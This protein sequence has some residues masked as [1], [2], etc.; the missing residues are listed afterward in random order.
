VKSERLDGSDIVVSRVGLGC[1]NFGGRLDL[2]RTREV[3][4]AALDAGITFFDTADIYGN[5]GNSERFLGEL[6]QGRRDRVVL[7]TKFGHDMGDGFNGS[8]EYAGRA[9]RASLERLRMDHVDLFYYH[10]PDGVTPLAETLGAMQELV[11]EGLTRAIGCSNFSAEQLAEAEEIAGANGGSR[12]VAVQNE[13]S[14]L[15]RE[16]EDHVLPLAQRLGVGFVPYF[17]L[18]S[19]LLTGKYRRD[20]PRPKGTRLEGREIDDATFDRLDGLQTFA[21]ERGHSLLELAIAALASQ[22]G[23]AS[24]IAGATSAEQIRQNADAAGWELSA[25]DL[26]ELARI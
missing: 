11:R 8:G 2:E 23:V 19:G 14:L 16:A 24:V 26:A 15:E 4:D 21:R 5:R 25:D 10:R 22:P 1:N 18:A 17:P 7:A 20:E 13:Y 6:L 3:V 9:L 12:F